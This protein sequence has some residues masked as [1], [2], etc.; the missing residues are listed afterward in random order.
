MW[1]LWIENVLFYLDFEL[2]QLNV[3]TKEMEAI[4][5][6]PYLMHD[7]SIVVK[8]LECATLSETSIALKLW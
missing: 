3:Y 2:F 4:D 8:V 7:E 6:R 5:A 1:T